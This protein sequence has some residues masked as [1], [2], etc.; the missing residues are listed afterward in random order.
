MTPNKIVLVVLFLYVLYS[1]PAIYCTRLNGSEGN[2][3]EVDSVE[4]LNLVDNYVDILLPGTERIIR[5]Q[6]AQNGTVMNDTPLAEHGLSQLI[7]VRRGAE[8]HTILFDS[9]YGPIALLHNLKYLDVDI[10]SIEA[11]VFSHGHMDHT[12]SVEAFLNQADQPLTVVVHPDAF[13]YPR[14]FGLPNG[15]KLQYPQT[16]RKEMFNRDNIKL[17]ES[18]DP[19]FLANNTIL[20]TGQIERTTPF[21]K[22]MPNAYKEEQGKIVHDPILDDQAL[23]I[24]LGQRGLVIVSGCAHA[25]IVNTVRYAT[26]ITGQP[27]VFAVIGGFHLTGPLFEPIINDTVAELKKY[28]PEVIV[29]MHCTGWKAMTVFAKELPSAFVLNS[30]GAKYVLKSE[31]P[32]VAALAQAREVNQ[33]EK[34]PGFEGIIAVVGFAAIT[35]F[36]QNRNRRW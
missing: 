34:L 12:G 33:T 36:I 7:T 5:P 32:K 13:L 22:G 2:L 30:V 11:V 26:N 20:I 15:V 8:K 21:E 16:F 17:I 1:A 24:N 3:Q 27:R 35:Y 4:I 28:S 9:G 14:Y 31:M 25:G 6:M 29:P 23:V 10:Q 19:S 18:K